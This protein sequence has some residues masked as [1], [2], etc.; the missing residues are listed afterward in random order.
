LEQSIPS[1]FEYLVCR[2]PERIA[3][4]SGRYSVT[5]ADLNHRAN[6][7]AQTLLSISGAN[8]EPVAT[9][10]EPGDSVIAAFLG[11]LKTGKFYVPM[12][13]FIPLP[14]NRYVLKDSQSAVLLTNDKNLSSAQKLCDSD[15]CLINIDHMD[16]GLSLENSGI[17][18]FPHDLAYITYTSGSTGDPKGVLQNHRN[19][20]HKIMLYTNDINICPDDR[21]A[22]IYAPSASGSA[23]DIYGALLNGACLIPF[24]AREEELSSL[25]GW[26]ISKC[27]TVYTISHGLSPI[28][29]DAE[30]Q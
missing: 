2:H 13:P 8:K 15:I 6:L 27:V 22:L 28:R 5:Y 1:R 9:L 3:I 18:I 10:L 14:R 20:L 12:D 11:I 26:L 29:G 4:K 17:F 19:L 21:L 23:R 16:S 24:N 7:V 25:A 30:R